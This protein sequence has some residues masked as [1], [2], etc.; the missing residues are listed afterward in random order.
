MS[1]QSDAARSREGRLGRI[2]A[3]LASPALAGLLSREGVSATERRALNEAVRSE[4]LALDEVRGLDGRAS[5]QDDARTFAVFRIAHHLALPREL[6]WAHARRLSRGASAARN[7]I[8]E[9]YARMMA[10]TDP[11]RYALLWDGRLPEPSPVKR[12]ALDD[13]A[14][15]IGPMILAADRELALDPARRRPAVSGAGSVSSMDYLMAELA[16]HGLDA[17]W[18]LR[19][20]LDRCAREG[21][22]PVLDAYALAARINRALGGGAS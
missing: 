22:N 14:A 11:D 3:V 20:G 5:C 7:G 4:W 15:R 10:V 16:C 13:I 17:L 2:D 1:R 18:A 8:E 6:L 12:A 9:K 19:D 21:R